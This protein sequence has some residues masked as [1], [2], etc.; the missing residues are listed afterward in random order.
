[1]L[2]QDT[3]K[4]TVRNLKEILE[5]LEA[6]KSFKIDSSILSTIPDVKVKHFAVE[7]Q[8]LN[9]SRMK[10]VEPH[11]RYVLAVCFINQRYSS[12]LDDIGE[13]FIKIIRTGGIQ[14]QSCTGRR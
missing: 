4:P 3:R 5:H 1:M 10:E 9:A 14:T 8:S 13:M 12:I 2:K 11:K 7:A 6:I